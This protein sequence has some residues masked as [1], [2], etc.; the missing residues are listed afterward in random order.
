MIVGGDQVHGHAL[1]RGDDDPTLREVSSELR[2]VEVTEPRPQAEVRPGRILRLQGREPPDHLD[3]IDVG[4]L[5]EQL[6]RERRAV[7]LASRQGQMTILP[8]LFPAR[9]R[10]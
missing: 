9:N 8:N 7:Q 4:T 10:S 2:A 6:A 3:G 1:Q 5:E